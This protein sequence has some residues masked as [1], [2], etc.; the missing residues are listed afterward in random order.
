MDTIYLEGREGV[1]GLFNKRFIRTRVMRFDMGNTILNLE[2]IEEDNT[3]PVKR[4]TRYDA[5]CLLNEEI[6][7]IL[8]LNH[9]KLF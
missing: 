2:E 9:K 7:K 4:S 5:H 3:T 6:I 1:P 8:S